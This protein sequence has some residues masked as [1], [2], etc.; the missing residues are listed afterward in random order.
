MEVFFHLKLL[1]R[2]AIFGFYA[3]NSIQNLQNFFQSENFDE[4]FES[5]QPTLLMT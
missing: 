3:P 5:A 1:I 2:Q 4:D